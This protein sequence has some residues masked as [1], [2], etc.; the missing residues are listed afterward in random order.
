MN[1]YSA[2]RHRN[3]ARF[4][5]RLGD[6]STVTTIYIYFVDQRS[7]LGDRRCRYLIATSREFHFYFN[8]E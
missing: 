3:G 1:Y 4:G 8:C 2:L 6:V 7:H 5:I